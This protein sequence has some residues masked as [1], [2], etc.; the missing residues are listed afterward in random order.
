MEVWDETTLAV[1]DTHRNCDERGIYAHDVTLAHFFWPRCGN[2]VGGQ[3]HLFANTLSLTEGANIAAVNYHFRD[4][5]ELLFAAV[6]DR[7]AEFEQR[8]VGS[9]TRST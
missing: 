1:Q 8:V 3:I 2:G 6:K 4:K 5:E 9:V 7:I